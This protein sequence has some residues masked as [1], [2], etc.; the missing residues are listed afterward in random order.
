MWAAVIVY[1]IAG[2][3]L[4]EVGRLGDKKTGWQYP[5]I[6]FLWPVAIGIV[7]WNANFRGK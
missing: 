2:V 3:F 5:V 4:A 1:L 6:C 7:L